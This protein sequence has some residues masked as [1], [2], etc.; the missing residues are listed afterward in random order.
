[1]DRETAVKLFSELN[2]GAPDGVV[3]GR[4]LE[5]FTNA[6]EAAERELCAKRF[7]E[8]GREIGRQ[9]ERERCAKLCESEHI[10]SSLT[11]YDLVPEDFSYNL[12]LQHAA[13]AIRGA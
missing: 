12:A 3:S 2:R 8:N 6:I 10:G 11:A 1:M 7:V 9:E 13:A 5:A 4:V